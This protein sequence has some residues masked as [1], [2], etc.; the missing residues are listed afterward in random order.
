ARTIVSV[1]NGQL[2]QMSLENFSM[3][4]KILFNHKILLGLETSADQLRFVLER[5]QELLQDHSKLEPATYPV[6]LSGLKKSGLEL[7]LFAYVLETEFDAF[8]QVQEELLLKIV[9]IVEASGTSFALP[10]EGRS[11]TQGPGLEKTES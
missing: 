10:I 4:D 3:R 9:D 5:T 1:P 7:E 6:R 11:T 2:A 8:L